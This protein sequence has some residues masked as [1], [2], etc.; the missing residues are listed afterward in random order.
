MRR[1]LTKQEILRSKQDINRI[2]KEGKKFSTLGMRLI[3]VGNELSFDRFIVIPAKHYGRA[4]DRN[5]IRRQVKE[6]WRNY[7]GRL[8]YSMHD[9]SLKGRDIALIVYPGKVFDFS[10]LESALT[11][12]LDKI[13]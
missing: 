10:L 7:S 13:N 6:I 4:V 8:L 12:L 9:P 2:F 1:N 5:R 11:K 3:V